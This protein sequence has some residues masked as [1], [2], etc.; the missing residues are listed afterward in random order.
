MDFKTRDH[1]RHVIEKVARRCNFSEIE[2]AQKASELAKKGAEVN[3]INDRTAHVGYFLIGKGLPQLERLT[4]VKRS[5]AS[6]FRKLISRFPLFFYLGSII[7]LTLTF[8]WILLEKADDDGLGGWHI[9]IF[10]VLLTLCTSYMS[11]AIVNWL[12]TLFVRPHP[13]PR[14]DYSHGIPPESMSLVII[15]AMIL[16]PQNIEELTESLEVR[17]LANQEKNLHFGLLTDFRDS[18]QEKMDDDE[19]LLQLV[20]KKITDLNQKYQGEDNDIF[21]LFHR[22][23]RWNPNDG[24]W[25]GYERKRGKLADLNSVLRG[26]SEKAFSLIIGNRK[27]MTKIKYVI[28]LDTDTQLPRDS[29]QQFVGA[30]SHPLN[31][32][33]FDSKKHCVTEGYSILQPR[34]AVSLPGTNRSGYAKLFGHEPGIDPYTRAVSDVY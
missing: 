26:G 12:A 17:F 30:M 11:I 2:V 3:G 25:M 19:A 4:K 22:P 15:P 20:S 9:W 10:G 16:N 31:K 5:P 23:R 18:G 33:V 32:P 1:Y 14:L 21:F 34:V 27:I 29:A 28:T 13:L 7:L 24:I 6:V 8:C